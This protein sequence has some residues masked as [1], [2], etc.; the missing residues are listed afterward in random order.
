M[1][2]NANATHFREA[3]F[4]SHFATVKRFDEMPDDTLVS[5]AVIACLDD[6]GLPTFYRRVTAGILPRPR[7]I[8]GSSRARVGDYRSMRAIGR[9]L[10]Q[11]KSV[12]LRATMKPPRRSKSARPGDRIAAPTLRRS[13]D[14]LSLAS[15][16]SFAD[17]SPMQSADVSPKKRRHFAGASMTGRQ[18]M[19]SDLFPS[20]S[21]TIMNCFMQS[22]S[23]S[24][25]VQAIDECQARAARLALARYCIGTM[26]CLCYGFAINLL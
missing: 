3:L 20:S 9:A 1:P 22:Q 13:F 8:G 4:A 25:A 19:V 23:R 15:R 10:G 14:D 12:R 11:A 7:R 17:I 26:L 16:R 21:Q 5:T 6:C 24:R 18:W 2:S